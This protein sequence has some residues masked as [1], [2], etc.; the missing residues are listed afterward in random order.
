MLL[1]VVIG[2]DGINSKMRSL[3]FGLECARPTYTHK[4]AYRGLIPSEEV[5]RLLG[6]DKAS[7]RYIHM[8]NGAHVLSCPVAGGKMVNVAAFVTDHHPWNDA[9]G[10]R[11]DEKLWVRNDGTRSEAV[12]A[13]A[14]AE[15]GATA[16][17]LLS[18]LPEK[19]D[20]WAIF[21]MYDHP[22]PRFVRGRLSLAGDAAHAAA[23]HHGAGA[24]YGIEDALVLAELLAAVNSR[25]FPRPLEEVISDLLDVYNEVRY[26]RCQALV[27]SSRTVGEMY[28]WQ[29]APTGRDAEAFN[30]EFRARCHRIWDYDVKEM[31]QSGVEVLLQRLNT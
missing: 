12:D 26:D 1:L 20:R 30:R 21:D 25:T 13:F 31:M 7:G 24:G 4:F 11:R 23:P 16:R 9:G 10:H 22:L 3:I 6:Q 5:R 18:L 27:E 2:C 19:L 28:E 15:V 29:Y 8:G 17:G 14:A